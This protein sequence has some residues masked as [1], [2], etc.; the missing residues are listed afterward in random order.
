MPRQKL[1]PRSRRAARTRS[2]AAWRQGVAQRTRNRQSQ[3]S[4]FINTTAS[5]TNIAPN[6]ES[7]GRP[8]AQPD[9]ETDIKNRQG[10]ATR[11]TS[12]EWDLP[13]LQGSSLPA[14]NTQPSPV[15]SN[16]YAPSHP[17]SRRSS[18]RSSTIA[19]GR[20]NDFY[21]TSKSASLPKAKA[22]ATTSPLHRA[23][24]TALQHLEHSS[25]LAPIDDEFPEIDSTPPGGQEVVSDEGGDLDGEEIDNDVA[26][27]EQLRRE[28][29]AAD[30]T[31]TLAIQLGQHLLQFHGCPPN[32]HNQARRLHFQDRRRLTNHHSLSDLEALTG[33]VPDVLGQPTLLQHGTPKQTAHVEWAR[34]FEGR[35]ADVDEGEEEEEEERMHVCLHSSEQRHRPTHIKYD[36]DSTLGY[37]TSLAFAKHGIMI[38]LAPQFYSNIR[39][40]LHLYTHVTHDYGRGPRQVRVQLHEVPHYCLGYLTQ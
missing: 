5:I 11:R 20:I 8:R 39:T 18:L 22:N 23:A 32:I 12:N 26:I 37:P 10:S 38:N 35:H 9:L 28:E 33:Q 31:A 17:E 24:F 1:S 13:P 6:Q 36:V 4:Q 30:P 29:L 21:R 27:Q 3:P 15:Q 40:N 19:R 7:T 16:Y 25:E 34:V 2:Q 14:S